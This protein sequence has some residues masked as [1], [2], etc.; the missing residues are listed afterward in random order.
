M[1]FFFF[2][3]CPFPVGYFSGLGLLTF[4]QWHRTSLKACGPIKSCLCS[5]LLLSSAAKCDYV[6]GGGGT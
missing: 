6:Q 5:T 3:K 1:P 4:L 2:F